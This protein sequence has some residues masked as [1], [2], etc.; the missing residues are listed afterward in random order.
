M[1]N[2]LPSLLLVFPCLLTRGC[3]KRLE[4]KVGEQSP[5][6]HVR[7]YTQ[8]QAAEQWLI[9]SIMAL[10]VMAALGEREKE[11]LHVS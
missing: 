6:A 10:S 11:V 7:T 8:P 1:L 9:L 5:K 3:Q 2:P 4:Q